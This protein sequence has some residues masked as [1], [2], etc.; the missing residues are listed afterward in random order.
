MGPRSLE[1]RWNTPCGLPLGFAIT[2]QEQQSWSTA[3]TM[4]VRV[5]K[6]TRQ[7]DGDLGAGWYSVYPAPSTSAL[8]LRDSDATSVV[9]FQSR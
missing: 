6:V 5:L 4:L 2:V 8:P 9:W 1:V 7:I 3:K